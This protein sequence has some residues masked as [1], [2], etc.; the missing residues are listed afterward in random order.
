MLLGQIYTEAE[1]LMVL[2]RSPHRSA[3]EHAPFLRRKFTSMV[4]KRQWAVLPYS[5]AKL[6]PGLRLSPPGVKE[7]RDRRPSWLGNYSFNAMNAQT[8]PLASLDAMQYGRA[9]D[10]LLQEIVFAEPS[11]GPVYMMKEDVSDGFYHI[12]L[13]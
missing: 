8:L 4:K 9:L 7:E 11:L 1:R 6:L 13:R 5:M 2:S 3:I 10:R 12:E